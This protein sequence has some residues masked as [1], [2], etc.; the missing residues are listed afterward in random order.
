M[1]DTVSLLVPQGWAIRGLMQ[2]MNGE[3]IS[4]VLVTAL[5]LLVWSAAFLRHRRVAFQQ[6][7]MHVAT[8]VGVKDTMIRIFDIALKDLLQLSRDFK[9]FMFLLIMPIF[10]TFLFG[11]AFG[12]FGGGELGLA[13]ASWLSVS[14]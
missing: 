13:P 7:R 9:T 6:T 4:S 8:L 11:F 3:P 12:G 10:F 5:V 2:A 14:R 1:G